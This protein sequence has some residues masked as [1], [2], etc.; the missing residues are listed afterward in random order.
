ML[1]PNRLTMRA[2]TLL[3]VLCVMI[4]RSPVKADV[5]TGL[6]ATGVDDS[7]AIQA[8]GAVDSHYTLNGGIAYVQSPQVTGFQSTTWITSPTAQWIGPTPDHS[9]VSDSV[10]YNYSTTFVLPSD[11]NLSSVSLSFTL[12]SDNGVAVYV[13]GHDTSL[14]Q[15]QSQ[16][17]AFTSFGVNGTSSPFFADGTNSLTFRVENGL[18][19]GPNPTGLLITAISGNYTE[20]TSVPEPSSSALFA[21]GGIFSAIAA[22]RKRM[23]L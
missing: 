2:R 1:Q 8:F 22:C 3:A 15:L 16:F 9:N 13:N 21:I 6:F 20:N 7:N 14:P 4:L 19:E 12:A 17:L 23:A 5:I 10:I 18:G 11:A